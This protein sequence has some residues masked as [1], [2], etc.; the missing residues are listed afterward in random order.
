VLVLANRLKVQMVLLGVTERS[1]AHRVFYGKGIER[2]LR[3]TTCDVGIYR[4]P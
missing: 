1:L 3:K 2:V 4:G